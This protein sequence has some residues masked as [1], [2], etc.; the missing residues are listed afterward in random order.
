[1]NPIERAQLAIDPQA[2]GSLKAEAR[3]EGG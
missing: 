3:R 2:L 1:M